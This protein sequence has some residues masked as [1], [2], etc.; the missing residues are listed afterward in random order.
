MH[1]AIAMLF[2]AMTKWP[3]TIR[4]GCWP[5]A[6]KF[7]V[8]V[9][10]DTPKQSGFTPKQ[11]FTGV[12]GERYFR[13]FHTFGLPT[14]VL[15]PVLRYGQKIPN[16]EPRS[17]ANAFFGKSSTHAGNISL[18]HDPTT[19]FVSSQFHLAHGDDFQTIAQSVSNALPPNWSNVFDVC[20]SADNETFQNPLQ[21]TEKKKT[22]KHKSSFQ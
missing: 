7:S 4:L 19:N 14:C 20:H 21:E 22:H 1:L 17:K 6:V 13:H 10:N 16:H 3:S 2:T 9:L 12:S 18:A 15:D 8:D 5:N 11:T